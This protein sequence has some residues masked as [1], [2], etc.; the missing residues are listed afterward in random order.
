MAKLIKKN[1]QI[2]SQKSYTQTLIRTGFFV[3]KKI[4]NRADEIKFFDT[5]DFSRSLFVKDKRTIVSVWSWR[6]QARTG[7]YGRKP[8]TRPNFNWLVWRTIRKWGAKWLKTWSYDSQPSETK[9]KIFLVA[10]AIKEKWTSRKYLFS[11]AFTTKEVD[12]FIYK[13]LKKWIT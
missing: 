9:W 10:R 2:F 3:R 7:E 5:G 6:I 1:R 4:Q 8:W 11:K 13:D 12:Q